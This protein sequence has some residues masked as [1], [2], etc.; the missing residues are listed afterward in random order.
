[1]NITFADDHD[2]TGRWS[3]RLEKTDSHEQYSEIF[4][5]IAI[6]SGH[7]H[8]PLW[9]KYDDQDK[10]RGKIIHS[11]EWKSADGYDGQTVIVVGS[12]NSGC[13]TAVELAPVANQVYLASRRGVWVRSRLGPGG[14]PLDVLMTT[15]AS[16][17]AMSLVPTFLMNY[18]NEAISNLNFN[19]ELYGLKPR[20]RFMEQHP[21]IN[22][23][24]PNYVISGRIKTRRNIERFTE[25]GVVFEGTNQEVVKADVVIFA[26]GFKLDVPFVDSSIIAVIDNKQRLFMGTF[27]PQ[28]QHSHTIG[29]IGAVQPLGPVHTTAEVG[30]LNHDHNHNHAH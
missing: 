29:L 10:F 8:T 5:A 1:M 24:L 18:V 30:F 15:R 11:N 26:T 14:R 7:H 21:T 27:N 16:K 28:L 23:M 20:H 25:D 17:V 12:G 13:D 9:P 22:D 3:V 19:H 2:R 6:A 4:D